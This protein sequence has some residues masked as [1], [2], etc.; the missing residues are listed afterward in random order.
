MA[1]TLGTSVGCCPR[2]GDFVQFFGL[3]AN[4]FNVVRTLGGTWIDP[5]SFEIPRC[6]RMELFG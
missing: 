2:K 6:G 1:E 4:L 3:P 5:W